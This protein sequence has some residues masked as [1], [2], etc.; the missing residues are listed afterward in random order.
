MDIQSLHTCI[1][2]TDGLKA[3]C[4][5][6][7]DRLNQSPSTDAFIRLTKL[8]LTLNYFSFNSSHF[9]QTKGTA[10]GTRMGT[11]Y[12]CL[13]VGDVEHPLFRSCT[14][15]IPHLFLRYIDDC[16]GAT[17]C[18]HQ[19]LEQFINFTNI[20]NPNLKFTWTI[21]DTSFSFL[22]LS[23]SISGNRLETDIYFKPTYSH[24][25]LDY[26]SSQPASCKNAISYS[27]FL[28]LC[29]VCF[30]DGTFHSRTSQMSSYFKDCNFPPLVVKNDLYRI[31]CISPTS[32]LTSPPRNKN[33]DR[34]SLVLTY[35]PTNF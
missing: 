32:A 11:S 7:S 28:P 33:K 18:S 4:F 10:M 20:F 1:P 16:I 35:H 34:I 15:T 27:Q 9:L 12:A 26:T 14:G 24:S 25:Y 30:Q 19:E 6:L 23:V 2:H 29:H 17:S 21:S 13:F 8:V 22:D 5:F 3:L 31:S